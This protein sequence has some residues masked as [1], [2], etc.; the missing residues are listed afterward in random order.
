MQAQ[1]QLESK[2]L[3]RKRIRGADS[4]PPCADLTPEDLTPEARASEVQRIKDT[5]EDLEDL[6]H[7]YKITDA[8]PRIWHRVPVALIGNL[9]DVV[10]IDFVVY[11]GAQ[12]F[13]GMPIYVSLKETM[14][15]DDDHLAKALYDA[16][17]VAAAMA[18]ISCL[19]NADDA[20]L[21]ALL[22]SPSV[23]LRAAP[24]PD[25][26]MLHM[27]AKGIDIGYYDAPDAKFTFQ[28]VGDS[29][30]LAALIIKNAPKKA[31][32]TIEK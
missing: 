11:F 1:A 4:A 18:S 23:R 22:D 25:E 29:E 27:T 31:R 6:A 7:P 17:K 16:P 24:D 12:S 14:N 15:M 13:S 32:R 20:A 28:D 3:E 8:L 5:L 21:L 26:M 19:H 30:S 10:T 2:K 9:T